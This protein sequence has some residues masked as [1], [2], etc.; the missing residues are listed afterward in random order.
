MSMGMCGHHAFR[1]RG[2]MRVG[3]PLAFVLAGGLLCLSPGAAGQAAGVN[4]AGPEAIHA[5]A[6][7]NPLP[8][9]GV[10]D[11][12]AL[13][14][15]MRRAER[16]RR[17]AADT[18]KLLQL[19]AELKAEIVQSPKDQLPLDALRKAAAI[20]KLARDVESWLKD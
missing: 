3:V 6:G 5:P 16:Q 8:D 20:E 1:N 10:P 9:H 13:V 17:L 15:K 19:S 12:A 11:D 7:M 4:Q 2:T 14:E 18:A